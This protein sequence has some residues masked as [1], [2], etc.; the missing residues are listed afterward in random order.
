MA[1]LGTTI[2]ASGRSR[3]GADLY[4]SSDR[5]AMIWSWPFPCS[6][7]AIWLS[8]LGT[9]ACELP[10]Q[11]VP[12]SAAPP[13]SGG[14]GTAGSSDQGGMAGEGLGGCT[15][16]TTS[17]PPIQYEIIPRDACSLEKLDMGRCTTDTVSCMPL[18]VGEAWT[19]FQGRSMLASALVLT[20]V[21]GDGSM[22]T[23]ALLP[24]G[25]GLYFGWIG[26]VRRGLSWSEGT[27]PTESCFELPP[28][29]QIPT[30]YP[31]ARLTNYTAPP[32]DRFFP[33]ECGN[34][35]FLT[36]VYDIENPAASDDQLLDV[37]VV[38]GEWQADVVGPTI[39]LTRR[40]LAT[41]FTHPRDEPD[42]NLQQRAVVSWEGPSVTTWIA[43]YSTATGWTAPVQVGPLSGGVGG[44]GPFAVYSDG[45]PVVNRLVTASG[46][47]LDDQAYALWISQEGDNDYRLWA[48]LI[49]SQGVPGDPI[50]IAPVGAALIVRRGRG[51]D[52]IHYSVSTN[53]GQAEEWVVSVSAGTVSDPS[54]YD[55]SP[56]LDWMLTAPAGA[57]PGRPGIEATESSVT[58]QG[59]YSSVYSFVYDD[60]GQEARPTTLSG[61]QGDAALEFS[62]MLNPTDLVATWAEWDGYQWGEGKECHIGSP[63][64]EEAGL[65]TPRELCDP[66]EPVRQ[67]RAVIVDAQGEAR[68]IPTCP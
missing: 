17:L 14:Q 27:A 44:N 31:F 11:P 22:G 13:S 9:P 30:E 2:T 8:M 19:D 16:T 23:P 6:L 57:A 65:T 56:P 51:P 68:C 1:R 38:A 32:D 62:G 66:P 60:Q 43:T 53:G 45:R 50:L 15:G 25:V 40:S 61:P 12:P 52:E 54:R 42:P 3:G 28:S 39:S 67:R 48:V 10:D 24:N 21:S 20:Q 37:G 46:I 41:R 29:D 49:D 5:I 7:G 58:G 55:P 33:D 26:G 35:H 18:P 36:D 64:Y 4:F 63:T 47:T 34:L 59:P